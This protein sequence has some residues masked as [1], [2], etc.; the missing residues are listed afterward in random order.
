MHKPW[1]ALQFLLSFLALYLPARAQTSGFGFR[2]LTTEDGLSQS[3][4]YAIQQDAAGFMW[5][6][7]KDG[8]DRYDGYHFKVFVHSQLDS[9]SLSDDF[10]T[11]LFQD[12]KKRLWVGTQYGN[13][14]LYDPRLDKFQRILIPSLAKGP[15]SIT[16]I[17][18]DNDGNLWVGTGGGG[19]MEFTFPPRHDN[20]PSARGDNPIPFGYSV[21]VWNDSNTEAFRANR[22]P[23]V[24]YDESGTMWI[25]VGD[26]LL[27]FDPDARS[28]KFEYHPFALAAGVT[29]PEILCLYRDSASNIW[30]G[31]TAGLFELDG[32]RDLLV[33]QLYG[34]QSG[35]G[36]QPKIRT[37]CGDTQGRL[38][39]GAFSRVLLFDVKR[40]QYQ[41][42]PEH[43][44]FRSGAVCIKRD[45]SGAIW[46]GSNGYG[47]YFYTPNVIHFESFTKK[48]GVDLNWPGESIRSIFEDSRE[49]LWIGTYGGL[50]VANRSRTSFR[51]VRTKL[52]NP[53]KSIIQDRDGNIWLASEL[54]VARM[55]PHTNAIRYFNHRTGDPA[56]LAFP[57]VSGIFLDRH[58]TIWAVT[59]GSLERLNKIS[60]TWSH[61]YFDSKA[62]P[63]NDP[64][65]TSICETP[66]GCL[67]FT[68]DKG[69]WQFN[70]KTGL[71]HQF[72]NGVGRDY[73]LSSNAT[74]SLCLDPSNPGRFLWV[75]TEGG[76]LGRLDIQTGKAIAFTVSDGLPDN[77][78]YSVLSD[79]KGNL[80]LSTND[81]L[82]K[83][84]PGTKSVTAYTQADGLQ[85]NEYNSGAYFK[86][87]DGELF[88]G[89]INGFD[90]FCPDEIQHDTYEPPVVMTGIYLFNKALAIGDNSGILRQSLQ[91]TKS[92]ALDYKQNVLSLT[93][94]ALDYTEP[95][96]NKYEYR[97]IGFDHDFISSGTSRTVT[98]TNLDPGK[99]T[100]VARGTNS[101]GTWSTHEARLR[102]EVLPP[103]WMTWWFRSIVAILFLSVGPVVYF[104]RISALKKEKG[105]RESFSRK[106]IENQENE[107]KRIAAEMH[108]GFGQN[109]LVM[110]N[111]ALLALEKSGL[112]EDVRGDLNEISSTA[113]DTLK[114]MREMSRNL[115]PYELDRFGV[116][117]AL[118][119]AAE[120]VRNSSGIPIAI[121]IDRID[122]LLSK[123]AEI[124]VYRVVQ[125]C[126]NNI[127]KHSRASIAEVSVARSGN[128]LQIIVRDN[129]IGFYPS[130]SDV[131]KNVSQGLGLDSIS[132]RVR[133]VGGTYGIE[134]APGEGTTITISVPCHEVSPGNGEALSDQ[135]S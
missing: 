124:N 111:R 46:L 1:R 56:S 105:Q 77:V 133:I 42:L 101:D 67:W 106:L 73:G 13:L 11:A 39:L 6:G 93:F 60:D 129:G 38:W 26:R 40:K 44:A 58:G 134:S 47:L 97:L 27:S 107:R 89:G 21:S 80:W 65:P 24:L 55:N 88:F 115:R 100:F 4:V 62:I 86:S 70:P 18:D 69:L 54:G 82:V 57:S 36:Q 41:T 29:R 59:P 117:E 72:E 102:I 19:L 132:E 14:N 34:N 31:T 84:K 99:Y 103:F 104:V 53:V 15:Y 116:T 28:K 127:I 32:Q 17:T 113:S 81:G 96:K 130:S 79:G 83:F 22:V 71:F 7:T 91:N 16:T 109:L 64:P 123:E 45:R 135:L 37:I 20:G 76:G 9:S 126:L 85:G 92:I 128:H 74:L 52:G 12:R 2:H 119:S 63:P 114:A 43:P 3:S 50:Y 87:R 120:R 90:A 95:G 30:A 125:E 110:K 131:E 35:S 25:G 5:F 121:E 68:S 8:L 78:V 66:D 94:A 98:Y 75:G 61:F 23:A 108:D 118:T 49:R 48:T 33:P 51:V 10:V 112:P 122:G